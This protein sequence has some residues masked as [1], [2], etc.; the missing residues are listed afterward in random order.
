MATLIKGSRGAAVIELQRNLNK[1]MLAGLME[2]GDFGKVTWGVVGFYQKKRGLEVTGEATDAVQEMLRKEVAALQKFQFSAEQLIKILP[3]PPDRASAWIGP[4][5]NA[6]NEFGINTPQRVA[7]WL[8]NLGH[9]SANFSR[10][11][12][13]LTYS[14]VGLSKTWPNRYAVRGPDGKAIPGK[15]NALAVQLQKDQKAIANITYA[16]RMGNGEP[17]SGDGWKFRGRGII[18]LTGRAAYE[19]AGK[20]LGV[21]LVVDPDR[22]ALPEMAA[23]IAGWFWNRNKINQ[24][25]DKGDFDGCC[26]AVN[27][28]R[29]TPKEGDALGYV[30]RKKH[31]QVGLTVLTT[32]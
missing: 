26:D 11:V 10:L 31:F 5:N 28:G 15:P 18:Q 12:E 23:R 1:I 13:D 20:A 29:K 32:G 17:T 9:E 22:A 27:I 25:I 6:A 7:A 24:W 30:E 2:D 4:L 21:D 19:E 8:A 14:A 16:N 3:M